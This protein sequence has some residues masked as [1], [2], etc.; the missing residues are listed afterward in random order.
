MRIIF[1]GTP[2]FAV[3]SLDILIKNHFNVCAVVTAAD[4]KKGRGLQ[5]M[6]TAVKQYSIEHGLNIIQQ[7]NLNDPGFIKTVT[8]L[9]PDLIIVVAFRIL[10]ESVYSIPN[11]GSFNL[12]ASLLPKYRGAAPIN[13]AIIK[14]EKES[15]VTSFF[16]KKKVD[17]GNII[18]QKKIKI[19]DEDNAGTLHDK[20][21]V[22]GA[23]C[24]LETVKLIES[25]KSVSIIQDDSVASPAPKIFKE[26]C[27]ID[28]NLN[29]ADI[30][31]FIRGLSPYPS[32]F[33]MLYDKS[34]KIL[35]SGLTD[36]PKSENNGMVIFRG[37]KLFVNTGDNLLEILELQF[38]GKKII[39]SADFINSSAKLIN[40]SAEFKFI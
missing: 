37:K 39:S 35:K 13:Y 26:H 36:I 22:L 31:N 17:T 25:G 1:M 20:L 21:S 34:V 15:G 27:R 12:H 16:L 6:P 7:E 4:K 24:V 23:E 32:A 5:I 11:L 33:T 38:E 40:N 3:P 9:R 10:P 28:W 29:S 2:D 8:E 19:E 18:L 30:H 14:G